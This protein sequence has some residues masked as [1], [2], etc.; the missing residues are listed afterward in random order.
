MIESDELQ[1][2]IKSVLED[3][4]SRRAQMLANL[5][6]KDVLKRKNPYLYKAR[7]TQN[8]AEII[9]EI[10]KA[11]LSSSDETIFGDAFFEP[12]ALK[13][14]GGVVSPSDGVDIAIE[15]D[16]RYMA[17]ALKSGPNIFNSSQAK[18]QNS[19]FLSLKARLHKI[20][21]QF[22]PVLGHAYG[23]KEAA[24][25]QSRVYRVVSGQKFW[26]EITGDSDFYLK[27]IRLMDDEFVNKQ[28]DAYREEFEKASNRY[29][30]E[31]TL[32][33]CK[34]DGAIDWE[35]LL[36]FNSGAKPPKQPKSSP[37]SK[38]AK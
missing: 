29:V 9:E 34:L 13:V 4:Y 35:K 20:K 26:Q 8:A 22:D 31:F 11:Y 5:Q 2:L 28:R 38:K 1:A 15:S 37:K 32:E 33:F 19:E 30:R 12:L 17:I 3:F 7:G 23:Q 27:L 16:E 25:N 18:K 6:L 14:S 10:L 24:S 21:K 36:H